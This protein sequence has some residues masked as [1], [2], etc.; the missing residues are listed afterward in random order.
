M[1]EIGG[2]VIC[3]EEALGLPVAVVPEERLRFHVTV[4]DSPSTFRRSFSRRWSF[5]SNDEAAALAARARAAGFFVKV[6]VC[7]SPR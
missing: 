3:G 1:I 5:R 6:D 7:L 4:A 2:V